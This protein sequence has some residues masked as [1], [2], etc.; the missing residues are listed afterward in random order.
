MVL[1][2]LIKSSQSLVLVHDTD[3]IA[4][5]YSIRQ[6][7]N[8]SLT[9]CQLFNVPIL[10]Y[11]FPFGQIHP[12]TPWRICLHL[13]GPGLKCPCVRRGAKSR[14]FSLVISESQ[15][16]GGWGAEQATGWFCEVGAAWKI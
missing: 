15:I 12:F 3:H 10:I 6:P 14:Y 1:D 7:L 13:L 11:L 8:I 2:L 9:P 5:L 4:R 16:V